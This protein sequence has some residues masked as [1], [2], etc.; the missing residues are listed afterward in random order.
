MAFLDASFTMLNDWVRE[1]N[2]SKIFIL[3]DEN[4]HTHCLP[5]F[6]GNL[7]TTAPFEILEIEAGEEMKNITSATMLWEILL[8]YEADRNAILVNL[9]G[10]VVT[11]LGGFVASTYKR[12]IDFLQIPTSLLAMVDASIG[13]K[14]GIDLGGAKN[15]VGTFTLPKGVFVHPDFLQTLPHEELMSG[16]AEMLKHGLIAD[17]LHWKTLVTIS[18]LNYE[19]LAPLIS[20]SVH[21]KK[22]IVERD[23]TEKGERKLLNFGHTIGHAIESLHL[24]NEQPILHGFAVAMGMYWEAKLANNAHILPNEDFA[25]IQNQL[26]KF[27]P[28]IQEMNY[29]LEMLLPFMKQDKKNDAKGIGFVA[30]ESIGR[31]NYHWNLSEEEL[32]LLWK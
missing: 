24:I 26:V 9:G 10:G 25:E 31:A 16:F 8:E 3:V 27:Y 18:E 11:D 30:L 29:T 12:G 28:F 20:D 17:V 21:I 13:G 6:L 19:N 32:K 5:L 1:R 2:P 15:M 14:T 4:T 7:E 23:P 22:T